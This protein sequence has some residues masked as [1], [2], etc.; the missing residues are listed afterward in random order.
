MSYSGLINTNINRA[1]NMV[2]DLAI[3][4]SLS[5]KSSASFDFTTDVVTTVATTVLT[6]AVITDATKTSKD[7]T[8]IKKIAML[9]TKNIGEIS[10]YDILSFD[11]TTWRIGP[12]INSTQ[13]ITIAE[14]YK[15]T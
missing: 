14:I 9:N 8:V 15:E 13:F 11:N 3:E 5:K 1:F 10:S 6:K 7:N 12:I 4:V 2:K